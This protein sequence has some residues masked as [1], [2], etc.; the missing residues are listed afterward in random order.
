MVWGA[1]AA[2]VAI[3]VSKYIAAIAT[4]SSA[5]LSEA[6]HS[7]ADS[8]NALLLILGAVLSHKPADDLHP[9]GRGK[10]IY[11]WGLI[12]AVVLFG[13]GGGLSFYEGVQH[14]LHPHPIENASWNYVVL[15]CALVFESSSFAI[16]AHNMSQIAKRQGVS[17]LKAAH[18]S[19]DPEH[20]V[21]LFEDT[22]A[23]LGVL[24]AFGGVYASHALQLPVLDGVA[25]I[26]IGAILTTAALFL[27]YECR[28]LLL[29]ESA[30]PKQIASI[31]AI[32]AADDAVDRVGRALT[33]FLGPE[34]VLLNLEVDFKDDRDASQ[35]EAAIRRIERAIRA[36][37]PNIHRI[38]IEAAALG[39][40]RRLNQR[41]SAP[42]PE[43]SV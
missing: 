27:A 4:G 34:E 7:T 41:A 30:D 42:N 15:G 31:R 36:R 25:S 8:G 21:V 24:V 40:G 26:V 6:I 37:H 38:F 32:V 13:L 35:V 17:F 2:N 16:A 9:F 5:L 29:G 22:A 11:F 20:F 1:L 28:S 43:A 23:I 18:D 3:A 14:V 39:G 19:K 33:M 12:V 10:E